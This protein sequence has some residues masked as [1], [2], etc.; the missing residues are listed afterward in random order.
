MLVPYHVIDLSV[1]MKCV[2]SPEITKLTMFIYKRDSALQSKIKKN[3]VQNCNYYQH[4]F[5]YNLVFMSQS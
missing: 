5:L 1:H 3:E 2:F 4:V